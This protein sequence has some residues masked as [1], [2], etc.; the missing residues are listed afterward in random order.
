MK[1]TLCDN[2]GNS[3]IFDFPAKDIVPLLRPIRNHRLNRKKITIYAI[4]ENIIKVD[5]IFKTI[6]DFPKKHE[7]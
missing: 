1:I 5:D 6:A 3:A 2:Y 4:G 7:T